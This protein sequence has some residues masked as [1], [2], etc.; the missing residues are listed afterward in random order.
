M[1]EVGR[2]S[3]DFRRLD[4]VRRTSGDFEDDNDDNYTA[5]Y[6]MALRSVLNK[7]K[8][9]FIP[10]E[11]TV[12]GSSRGYGSQDRLRNPIISVRSNKNFD[13]Q[14]FPMF[15]ENLAQKPNRRT[16]SNKRSTNCV[17]SK[18]PKN[19]KSKSILITASILNQKSSGKTKNKENGF[20]QKIST[21]EKPFTKSSN[22]IPTGKRSK[23]NVNSD[24]LAD[25]TP[26]IVKHDL[27]NHKMGYHQDAIDKF[28]M[29]NAGNKRYQERQL[30]HNGDV[31]VLERNLPIVKKI[32]INNLVLSMKEN[33]NDDNVNIDDTIKLKIEEDLIQN[34]YNQYDNSSGGIA[35]GQE[36]DCHENIENQEKSRNLMNVPSP[37]SLKITN[38]SEVL[39]S[40]Q[41]CFEVLNYEQTCRSSQE[42]QEIVCYQNINDAL[43][44]FYPEGNSNYINYK[45]YSQNDMKDDTQN[46]SLGNQQ[47]DRMNFAETRPLSD[48]MNPTKNEYMNFTDDNKHI[49]DLIINSRQFALLSHTK[50]EIIS[51]RETIEERESTQFIYSER[52]NTVDSEG[53]YIDGLTNRDQKSSIGR[54]NNSTSWPA[55]NSLDK[56]SDDDHELNQFQIQNKFMHNFDSGD[57]ALGYNEVQGNHNQANS[58]SY[59][60]KMADNKS[61][62]RDKKG[63]KKISKRSSR[64]KV[65]NTISNTS[66]TNTQ[67]YSNSNCGRMNRKERCSSNDSLREASWKKDNNCNEEIANEYFVTNPDSR[68]TYK[69]RIP[70][71]RETY[72]SRIR[73]SNKARGWGFAD[74]NQRGNYFQQV[75]ETDKQLHINKYFFLNINK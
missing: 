49:A 48:Y 51:E 32:N 60:K 33:L 45:N 75:Y 63:T 22:K 55:L 2:T 16:K 29:M 65:N 38:D 9:E 58:K 42:N 11:N 4:E 68:E 28:N 26:R 31:V 52:K 3:D 15:M 20:F 35:D 37:E 36:L 67:N 73:N 70:D 53:M 40:E 41:M 8:S 27:V 7:A 34:S 74:E 30:N 39:N 47:F 43:P 54:T 21:K 19:K 13:K 69:S 64:S 44:P 17:I 57:E 56:H 12:D 61:K 14:K 23:R 18:Q 46:K 50:N 5:A 59:P 72:T 62:K 6:H 24:S 66:R 10:T 25:M 71:S 1:D